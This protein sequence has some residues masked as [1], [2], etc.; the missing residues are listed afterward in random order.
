M[1][2]GWAGPK[3]RGEWIEGSFNVHQVPLTS[4]KTDSQELEAFQN[5]L[6][7]YEVK[8]LIGLKTGALHESVLS[9]I[10]KDPAKK[11][12]QR[13]EAYALYKPL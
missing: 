7:S 9:I 5:W 4:A 8:D 10:P 13:K 12:G 2:K 11:M 3:I 6:H 1:E